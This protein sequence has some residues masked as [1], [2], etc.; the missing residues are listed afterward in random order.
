MASEKIKV[1]DTLLCYLVRVSRWCG[2]LR[3]ISESYRDEEP[4][5]QDPD[6]YVVRFKVEPLIILEPEYSLPILDDD[7]WN[8]LS[9]TEGIDKGTRG[10]AIQ[11]RGSLRQIGDS[12]G[13]FLLSRLKKQEEENRRFPF[14]DKDRRNFARTIKVR[15]PSG[16]VSVEIP[17]R[18]DHDDHIETGDRR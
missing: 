13:S 14:T 2:A 11:Y 10:W 7:I 16:G 1:G 15:T 3:I 17:E 8:A 4:I 12:D 6:P 9:E 5:F 18:D